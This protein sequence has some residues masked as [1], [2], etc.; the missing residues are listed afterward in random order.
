MDESRFDRLADEA[1]HRLEQALDPLADGDDFDLENGGGI[2]T[3]EFSD[4]AK[5]VVNSHR[6]ARQIW[7]SALMHAAHCSYDEGG[8]RW[9][10]SYS[11][12]ELHALLGEALSTKLGRPV[13][14]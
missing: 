7:V 3:L 11:G 10:D 8:K 4:G 5:F 14:L 1:L 13:A 2:L 6:A 9:V 12:K